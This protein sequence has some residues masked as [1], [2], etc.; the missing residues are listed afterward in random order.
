MKKFSLDKKTNIKYLLTQKG[1]SKKV[2]E[3]IS[4]D[5]NEPNWMLEYRFKA[6][7]IFKKLSFPSWGPDLSRLDLDNIYY[8]ANPKWEK[9]VKSWEDVPEN[10]K[11]TFQK[12]WLPQAEQEYLAWVWA[13]YDSKV[14]YHSLKEE[15]AKLGIIFEDMTEAL[16]KYPDLVKKYFT[17][18]VPMADHKFAALHYAIWSGGTFVYIPKEVELEEPLQAYFRMNLETSGQFE[19]TIIVL[20]DWAKAHYIEWCSA[21]KY[22]SSSLHA[23]CVE[24]F[25]WKK[26]NLRYSSVE[27]WS[28]NTFNL[29]TK[30]AIIEEEGFIEWVWGNMWAGVT[31]LYPCSILKWD[32]SSC[33]HIWIAFANK[34]Q[35]I[36]SWTKVI[37][38]GKNTTS[39]VVSKS[40]SKWWWI[41]VYRWLLDIKESAI[42]SVA[43][44]ECDGL[45]LDKKSLNDTFPV[46]Q[47]KDT[48]STVAHE[49]KVGKINENDLFYL[50]SRWIN[51]KD[52][53]IMIVNGF[54]NPVIKELP[55]EY[56]AEMNILIDMEMN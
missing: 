42:N 37:H 38:I 17:K 56:A 32:R 33:S 1:L 41:S 22:N 39:N 51:K 54:I 8:Y 10:I 15:F 7:E 36:D 13:Q 26:A 4:S 14:M 5:N 55:L 19:H 28:L 45:I 6:F 9:N 49:A 29:N 16:K 20:E 40:L 21:P 35:I 53:E 31:M 50:C 2:I 23:W 30:R 48:N 46:I 47:V 34:W 11:N 44:I 12:L 25:V 52:A 43:K 27:N 18:A 3:T 24:V